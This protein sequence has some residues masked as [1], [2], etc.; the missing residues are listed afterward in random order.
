MERK[1][2]GALGTKKG[3]ST[4]LRPT[5]ENEPFLTSNEL[6]SLT[7]TTQT[8]LKENP[9]GAGTAGKKSEKEEE[10][11]IEYRTQDGYTY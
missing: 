11:L 1:E 9:R 5:R 8:S 10:R 3:N 7:S 4:G 2:A 6:E